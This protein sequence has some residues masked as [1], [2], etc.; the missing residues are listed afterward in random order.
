[1]T[2]NELW[3]SKTSLIIKMSLAMTAHL[4]ALLWRIAYENRYVTL[5][6]GEKF[7][8]KCWLSKTKT[9]TLLE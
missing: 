4:R 2:I 5:L 3:N 6:I 7:F 1:M 8:D 9:E